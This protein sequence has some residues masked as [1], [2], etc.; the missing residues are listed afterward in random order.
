[1]GLERQFEAND[2]DRKS[3]CISYL[4]PESTE[5]NQ[6]AKIDLCK[7]ENLWNACANLP[8]IQGV[9]EF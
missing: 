3:S 5:R 1:M 4:R 9:I 7:S 8:Q 6:T 2:A